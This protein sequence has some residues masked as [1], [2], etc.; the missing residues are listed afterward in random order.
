MYYSTLNDFLKEKFGT[1]VI[2]LSLDGHNSCP[3]RINNQGGCIFCSKMGAGEF[4][5]GTLS[6]SEQL[7]FQKKF[8][9]KKWK[10][11]KYIAYFQNFT[12]TYGNVKRLTNMYEEVIQM[13][14][15]V[16][17]SIATR[18]DC[19]SDEIMQMLKTLNSKTFLW[20]E[21]GLQT[22]NDETIKLINRGYSHEVFDEGIKKLKD[23]GINFLVHVIYGL[24]YETR[25][26][27]FNT[28]DYVIKIKPFGVKFHSLYIQRDSALFNYYLENDI[29]L[30]TK[31]E[32]VEIVCD[33]LEKLS[34]DIVV[35][36]ITGDPDRKVHIAPMWVRDKLSVISEIHSELKRRR[37]NSE[38]L[39]VKK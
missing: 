25:K 21:L 35:H 37:I 5:D 12:N 4:T 23:A 9:S 27:Y 28:L 32:Y 10:S 14:G 31:K 3:N 22:V 19:L 24:P 13:E 7:K 8:M 2:K 30:I 26:D 29:K 33:S 18:A 15:I 16:G 6:V 20:V 11:D 36:R 1:K 34:S 17:L 38:V 39:N